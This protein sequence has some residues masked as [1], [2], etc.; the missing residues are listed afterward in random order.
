LKSA[1]AKLQRWIDLIAALLR[2]HYG[3]TLAELKVMIPGYGGDR[4][5]ATI[6]RMFERDKDE[7][8]AVGLPIR[9]RLE[10][11]DEGQ[12]QRYYMKASEMYLPY[13]ALVG[14]GAGPPAHLPPVGY[15][16]VP[17]LTFEPDELSALVR[18][19][20]TTKAVGDPALTRD[21]DSAIRKLT[22]DLGVALGAVIGES[23]QH[24]ARI[25]EP[26][27]APTVG[28]LGDALLRRKRVD[29]RYHSMNRDTTEDR[30]AEPYGLFFASG[31]WY[32][33]GRDV[34]ADGVRSFRVSRMHRVSANGK[35]PQ[36]PDYQIPSD[37][38]LA[39]HAR[40]KEPWELG[41]EA[42]REMIVEIR[43]NTGASIAARSLGSP[44]A[45]E[46]NQR[47]F[48]VRRIDSFARWIMSFVGDVVPVS[49][50][51]L[52]EQYRAVLASTAALYED[53]DQTVS[54]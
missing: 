29:F 35:K 21:A 52:I 34:A 54:G 25:P 40:A 30:I 11:T 41:D 27:A 31:H 50:T 12:V 28:I 14:H 23:E 49:P 22:Y 3:A 9:V 53:A 7:L 42:S 10:D 5:Q 6:D 33:A 19:A 18:A 26:A 36:S 16:S 38:H 24:A 48:R 47:L 4:A 32:L 20:R 43:G 51:E 17:T 46:A 44:V 1:D 39:E 37:F 13:L 8:R 2:H 45:C 15:R